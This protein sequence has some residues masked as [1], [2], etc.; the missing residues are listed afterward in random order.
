MFVD[1]KGLG[2]NDVTWCWGTEENL[3]KNGMQWH[4]IQD[5]ATKSAK[6]PIHQK[7]SELSSV[8][9]PYN[10]SYFSLRI[11]ILEVDLLSRT[12][13]LESGY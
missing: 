10:L 7:W 8:H 12:V 11:P 9:V 1:L 2:T 3:H 4:N 5:N 13:D 6:G